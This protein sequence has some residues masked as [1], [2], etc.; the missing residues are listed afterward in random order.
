M[1]LSFLAYLHTLAI[2]DFIFLPSYKNA[3]KVL[4]VF[5]KSEE[6]VEEDGR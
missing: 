3:I 2:I 4:E 5:V 1:S 6:C